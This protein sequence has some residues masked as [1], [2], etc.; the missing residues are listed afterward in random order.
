MDNQLQDYLKSDRQWPRELRI[1]NA[2][3]QLSVT[4]SPQHSFWQA[5]IDANSIP[6]DKKR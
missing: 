3:Y 2:R 5:V 1:A 6:Q 4:E